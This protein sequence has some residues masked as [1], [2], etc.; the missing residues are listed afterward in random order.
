MSESDLKLIRFILK[1]DHDLNALMRRRFVSWL[2]LDDFAFKAAFQWYRILSTKET[3]KILKC[4]RSSADRLCACERIF[5]SS[6]PG[7]KRHGYYGPSILA[8]ITGETDLTILKQKIRQQNRRRKAVPTYIPPEAPPP[9]RYYLKSV[10][11]RTISL[12]DAVLGRMHDFDRT[13]SNLLITA[14]RDNPWRFSIPQ[15]FLCVLKKQEAC[16]VLGC[17]ASTL[18]ALVRS[19]KILPVIGS[20]KRALGYSGPSVWKLLLERA[21]KLHLDRKV[22]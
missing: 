17:K 2:Q 3:C 20:G 22:A 7:Y 12:L 14:L 21:K 11:E 6:L 9:N 4:T 5:A 13:V 1:Q 19:R 10:N 18:H 8:L 16:K 15:K